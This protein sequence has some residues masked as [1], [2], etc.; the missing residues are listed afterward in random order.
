MPSHPQEA[1]DEFQR[2]Q[3]AAAE[4]QHLE[5]IRQDD[6]NLLEELMRR[7]N[8]DPEHWEM[9]MP[10]SLFQQLRRM[11]E[12]ERE[13]IGKRLR[14]TEHMDLGLALAETENVQVVSDAIYAEDAT[15]LV[16]VR[17]RD[18]KEETVPLHGQFAN[19]N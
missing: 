16:F 3:E 13:Q 8:Y 12:K 9:T 6:T 17:D 2:Q 1:P 10:L 15:T 19:T 5:W 7:L 11:C 14:Q 4:Q 18:G